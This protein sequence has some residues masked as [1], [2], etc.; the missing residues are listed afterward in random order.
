M[1]AIHVPTQLSDLSGTV[2]VD[3]PPATINGAY[4]V[5]TPFPFS[6]GVLMPPLVVTEVASWPTMMP[7]NAKK[8][9]VNLKWRFEIS[10]PGPGFATL[11]A[12]LAV[13]EPGPPLA[14]A[15][16]FLPFSFDIGSLITTPFGEVVLP[17]DLSLFTGNLENA[18]MFSVV[19]RGGT[20]PGDTFAG[21]L[22]F[23]N[24]FAEV[25]V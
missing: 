9:N 1:A 12:A 18:H 24:A 22:L 4:P 20:D 15:I 11:T 5:G 13:F 3:M 14:L 25:S 8:G 2:H 10:A 16:F 6:T 21:T 7:V 17:C 19:S 23:D